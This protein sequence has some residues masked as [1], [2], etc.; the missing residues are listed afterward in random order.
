LNIVVWFLQINFTAWPFQRQVLA[1]A[2]ALFN[3]NTL[4][5]KMFSI[6]DEDTIHLMDNG[7]QFIC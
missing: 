6:L 2:V 7:F 4:C 1:V 5:G 3:L